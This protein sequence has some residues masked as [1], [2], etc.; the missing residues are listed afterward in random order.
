MEVQ[1]KNKSIAS[2]VVLA[3]L[4]PSCGGGGGG[5]S[6]FVIPTPAMWATQQRVPTSSD[7]RW[8]IFNGLNLG[9]VVGKDG[10]IFRTDDGGNN[11]MQHDFTPAYR[12]GDIE[13]VAALNNVLVAVGTDGAT[14]NAR[15]WT[16]TNTLTWTTADVAA[17]GSPYVDVSLSSLGV[18]PFPV[19]IYRLRRNGTVDF[20][21]GTGATSS[22]PT[23]TWTNANGMAFLG[24][25]GFGYFCGDNGGVGQIIKT[26]TGGAGPVTATLPAGTKTLRRVVITPGLTPFAVGDN[27]SDNG[28]VLWIPDPN[29]PNTWAA[30]GNNPGGLPSLQAVFFP[31]D[32]TLGWVV[33]NGGTIYRLSFNTG[34]STWT[35][36]NQNPGGALTTENLYSVYFADANN[37]W[38]VGDKGTV[39]RTTNGSTAGTWTK[40]NRGDAGINWNAVSFT[41]DGQRGIAVGNA[42]AGNASKI[43]RTIDGGTTWTAMASAL[44]TQN[45]LGASVPRSGAGTFAYVCGDGGTLLQNNNVWATVPGAWTSVVAAST[46][47][48]RAIHFPQAEDKG[49]CVGNTSGGAPVLLRTSTGTAWLAPATA[50]PTAP[51]ASYNALSSNA[52]GTVVYASGGTNGVVSRSTDLAGGWNTWADLTPPTGLAVTLSSV[53]SPEGTAFTAMASA[54]NGNVYKLSAGMTPTWT[55]QAATPWGA[56]IPV[57]LAFQSD[58]NGLVVTNAGGVYYTVDGGANWITTY[59][60]TKAIPRA[61]WMSP[62][63]PGLGYI[64]CDDGVIMKTLTSGH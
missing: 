20:T 38:I 1:L 27:T 8:V 44:T 16:S 31:N 18:G 61:I 39:L 28:I 36:T 59:P 32:A 33:G 10:T 60:H 54:S 13:V 37:G 34:T 2:L 57:S 11:W 51:S 14:G 58:L 64:V 47:T 63:V 23:G 43:Y 49:V 35:W 6:K 42:A 52:A 29:F 56:A 7:L 48:Y 5:D 4:A 46:N 3:I 45:L 30:V 53:A 50:A 25:Q 24:N 62:T 40:I 17:T 55:P 15:H 19:D 21:S 9:I 26:G 41:N 22:S 12:T